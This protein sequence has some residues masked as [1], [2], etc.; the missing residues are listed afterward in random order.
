MHGRLR[1]G[2][3][4]LA[5]TALV[6][7]LAAVT[8]TAVTTAPASGA[9]TAAPARPGGCPDVRVVWAG[10][11]SRE[12]A[13]R[14]LRRVPGQR[15]SVTAVVAAAPRLSLAD[16]DDVRRQGLRHR[17]FAG[18]RAHARHAVRVLDRS[19]E[20][21]PGTM[22]VLGGHS[23]GAVVAREAARRLTRP[24]HDAARR[25]LGGLWLLG[26]PLHERRRD[27]GQ[28]VL[29]GVL[30]GRGPAV[31]RWIRRADM[32]ARSCFG[33]EPVCG[34]VRGR[35]P[36][37]DDMWGHYAYDRT[38]FFGRAGRLPIAEKA[39]WPAIGRHKVRVPL[40]PRGLRGV[41]AAAVR[42]LPRGLRISGGHIV[43]RAPHGRTAVRLRVWSR[44]VAPAVRRTVTVVLDAR[45]QAAERGTVLVSRGV[46]SRP[47]NAPS[48][49]ASVSDDARVVAYVSTATNLVRGDRP[50]G[51]RL[52]ARAYAWDATTGRT[53][54]V[55]VDASGRPV[56][57][58]DVQVSGSGR[59]VLFHDPHAGVRWLRDR[60]AGTSVAVPQGVVR[61]ASLSRDGRTVTFADGGTTRRWNADSGVVEDLGV[62]GFQA[63]S[64]DGMLL[65]LVDGATLRIWDSVAGSVLASGEFPGAPDYCRSE[66]SSVSDDGRYVV[67]DRFCDRYR[68]M[69]PLEV[70]GMRPLGEWGERV[71]LAADASAWARVAH[72]DTVRMQRLDG[73]ERR[74]LRAPRWAPDHFDVDTS[75]FVDGDELTS[76]SAAPGGSAVVFGKAGYDIVPGAYTDVEQ[77][78]LWTAG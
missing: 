13:V 31:P 56:G 16:L 63:A 8:T 74:L 37:E 54:L 11:R 18:W 53:E 25:H 49:G 61:A 23:E 76:V 43:G 21:C 52:R 19:A 44:V 7:G 42:K 30:A 66:V 62:A 51:R 26:D 1:N 10:G 50:A 20:A 3:T 38:S 28:R 59:Y 75:R 65:A 48:W 32:L 70:S 36:T 55:S 60:V 57:A 5:A 24:G 41:R 17:H 14:E 47:A 15:V 68:E 73:T 9:P 33:T 2:V 22:L 12:A 72:D 77:V 39:T 4:W 64:R 27:Q 40:S 71:S 69:R 46:D 6:T 78:Y 58:S 35:A 45:R 34:Q 29:E 67:E